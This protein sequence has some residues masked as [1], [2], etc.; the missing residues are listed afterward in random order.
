[1][2][3]LI[4]EMFLSIFI[5]LLQFWGIL[6]YRDY[7][8]NGTRELLLLAKNLILM[9]AIVLYGLCGIYYG[10]FYIYAEFDNM[11]L[12]VDV[13]KNIVGI[14]SAISFLPAVL[15]RQSKWILLLDAVI[16]V[17]NN[18]RKYKKLFGVLML[19][20]VIVHIFIIVTCTSKPRDVRF[21]K[22]FNH[23]QL[24]L[25][26]MNLVLKFPLVAYYFENLSIV[27][28]ILLL[29]KINDKLAAMQNN[30]KKLEK[31]QFASMTTIKH[32][33]RLYLSAMKLKVLI[34]D[35]F[36]LKLLTIYANSTVRLLWF[37]VLSIQ[38]W[39]PDKF[40]N[41]VFLDWKHLAASVVFG[42]L[43]LVSKI[44]CAQ[45]TL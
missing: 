11:Y 22:L 1:M 23:N 4:L 37:F 8:K 16:R 14:V 35:Y 32:S 21:Q 12:M 30:L 43:G 17:K 45:M 2:Y 20:I 34:N 44:K 5:K 7:H 36:G 28:M 31:F 15:F 18:L 9:V 24:F 42:V 33:K 29:V 19:Y 41:N 10:V 40:S 38:M 6:P 13:L 25:A 27:I 3:N 26:C 39:N